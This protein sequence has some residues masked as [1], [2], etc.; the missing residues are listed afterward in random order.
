MQTDR[1]AVIVSELYNPG[2]FPGYPA[3]DIMLTYDFQTDHGVIPISRLVPAEIKQGHRLIVFVPL[4]IDKVAH[5]PGPL[6]SVE[7]YC[8]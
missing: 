8:Q 2:G 3:T 6:V 5:L 7:V 1:G 4:G